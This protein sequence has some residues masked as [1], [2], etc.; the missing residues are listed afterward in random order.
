MDSLK[1][2]IKERM[3]FQVTDHEVRLFGYCKNCRE[4]EPVNKA[5]RDGIF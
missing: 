4:K 5:G 1:K 3:N 2:H